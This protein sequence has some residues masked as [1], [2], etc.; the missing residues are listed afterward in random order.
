MKK[1]YWIAPSNYMLNPLQYLEMRICEYYNLPE[2]S[3]KKKHRTK[4]LVMARK[5]FIYLSDKLCYGKN[6]DEQAAYIGFSH[7]TG[8]HHRKDSLDLIQTDKKFRSDVLIIE[9]SLK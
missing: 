2:G 9:N 7:S 1:N 6:N 8:T 5:I 4:K 3:I